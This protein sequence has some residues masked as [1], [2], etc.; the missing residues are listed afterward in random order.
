VRRDSAWVEGVLHEKFREIGA[1]G[2][3]YDRSQV[4]A[5]LAA[6]DTDAPALHLV[7]PSAISLAENLIQLRWATDGPRPALRSSL[8]LRVEGRWRMLFHQGTLAAEFGRTPSPSRNAT[9]PEREE[10]Y[11]VRMLKVTDANAVYEAFSSHPDMLRQGDADT[12]EKARAYVD[13][14][15]SNDQAQCPLAITINDRLVGLVCGSVDRSNAN[16]WIWYWMHHEYRGRSLTTR[17]VATLVDYLFDELRLYRLELGLRANNPGSRHV[18]ESNGFLREGIERGKF[19]IDGG[20]I[21]VYTYARLRTDP[22][23]P[24]EPLPFKLA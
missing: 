6:E 3:I 16:A 18:A 10:D 4:I 1:S 15:L 13:F 23:A 11:A 5:L 21:D 19:L 22:P 20:R 12:P 8:W 2:R 14:L 7:D 24:V 9:A 17:A